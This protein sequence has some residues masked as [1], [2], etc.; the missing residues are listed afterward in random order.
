[1]TIQDAQ[2]AEAATQMFATLMG[3]DVEARRDYLTTNSTLIPPEALD[4]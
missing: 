4:I 3:S 2:A 1:M